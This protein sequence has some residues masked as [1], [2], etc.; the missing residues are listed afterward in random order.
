MLQIYVKISE[1]RYLRFMEINQA[2]FLGS[3]I[4]T[5]VPAEN[6]P[7]EFAFIGRSNVG[8]SSL[9]NMLCRTKGLAHTS[10]T[11]GKTQCINKFLI[12]GK[13]IITD[14]PGYGFA[15]ISKTLRARLEIMVQDYILRTP[16]MVLLFVLLDCRHPFQKIDLEFLLKLGSWQIPFAVALTK[17]DKLSKTAL[18]KQI[19]SFNEALS[20]YWEPL[21]PLFAVS[22]KTAS[23]RKELLEYMG[24]VLEENG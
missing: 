21:P 1:K 2:L 9:I 19:D 18:Q 23:G 13:W 6:A 11:P 5:E 20:L 24:S 8:K 10:A 22:S 16:H 7:V 12:N 17:A 15:K 14:L 3:Y 4:K